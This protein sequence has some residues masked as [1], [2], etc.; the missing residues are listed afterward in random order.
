MVERAIQTVKKLLRKA[1]YDNKD[2]YLALLALRNTPM[3]GMGS[4]VQLL[5]SRRTRTLIPTKASLLEPKV[6]NSTVQRKL[7]EN[8]AT[9]KFYYDRGSKP[10][11]DLY[12]I[13][14]IEETCC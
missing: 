9:R 12:N 10:L 3:E 5:M 4:P 1:K 2:P 13:E 8:Q 14:E 11:V 6:E 7:R